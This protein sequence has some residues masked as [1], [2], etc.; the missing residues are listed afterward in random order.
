MKAT[1]QLRRWKRL[2]KTRGRLLAAQERKLTRI[3]CDA[4]YKGGVQF[5]IKK[6]DELLIRYQR[7]LLV[8]RA[9]F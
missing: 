4:R 7:L 9:K 5:W 8:N 2:A 6:H 1:E 3:L